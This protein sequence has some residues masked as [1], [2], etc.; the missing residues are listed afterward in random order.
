[1]RPRR[2]SA[3]SSRSTPSA[4]H[5]P[6][7]ACHWSIRNSRCFDSEYAEAM[8]QR[9][10]EHVGQMIAR[11]AAVT[12]LIFVGLLLCGIHMRYRQRGPLASLTRL[13]VLLLLAIATVGLARWAGLAD[14]W[15]GE[16][17]PVLLFGMIMA[18]VYRQRTGL[19]DVRS[20]DDDRRAGH[21]TRAVGVRPADGRDHR[22]RAQ[23]GTH[24]Q[25]QQADLRRTVRRRR[26]GGV[27]VGFRHH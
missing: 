8:A 5:W 4:S 12:G 20:G 18:I 6:R 27:A 23:P 3:T 24:P 13:V 1:M 2:P 17:V 19:A 26:G 15:R 16:L 9:A 10:H 14:A 7:L 25:P 21:R 11:F 22:R